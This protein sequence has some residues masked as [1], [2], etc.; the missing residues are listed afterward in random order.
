MKFIAPRPLSLFAVVVCL[1]A[2]GCGK[3]DQIERAKKFEQLELVA[4]VYRSEKCFMNKFAPIN[5]YAT[6]DVTFNGDGTGSASYQNFSDAGCTVKTGDENLTFSEVSITPIAGVNV[7]RVKQN[8]PVVDPIWW[9]PVNLSQP[10]YS[11][12]VDHTDGES[13]PYIIEPSEAD[14]SSFKADPGQGVSFKKI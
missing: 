6:A 10:G 7:I 3:K 5:K 4:G 1:A 8:A 9:I 12:D 11:L 2:F 14:L 13:G